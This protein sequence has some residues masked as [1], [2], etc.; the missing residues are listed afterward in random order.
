MGPLALADFIGLD[1]VLDILQSLVSGLGTRYE[2]SAVLHELVTQGH[3][4]RKS[5]RG[6]FSY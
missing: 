5:G 2:P 6:F 1:V 3:L 4:G